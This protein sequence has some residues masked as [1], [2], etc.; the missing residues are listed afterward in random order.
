MPRQRA[1]KRGER[2]IGS[3]PYLALVGEDH[4][5]KCPLRLRTKTLA[6]LDALDQRGRRLADPPPHLRRDRCG[7]I[8]GEV[9]Q[10]ITRVQHETTPNDLV[11][12]TRPVDRLRL[13]A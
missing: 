3:A 4:P 7:E 12:E 10:A 13:V 5:P 2:S 9:L 8:R 6:E 11:D 1:A